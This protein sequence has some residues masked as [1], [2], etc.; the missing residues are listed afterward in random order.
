MER[1]KNTRKGW[2]RNERKLMKRE[3]EKT[4][5]W[6]INKEKKKTKKNDSNKFTR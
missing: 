1:K 6:E 3:R 4:D 2:E 5:E